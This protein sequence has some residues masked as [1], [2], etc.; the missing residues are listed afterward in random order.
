MVSSSRTEEQC[1]LKT[2]TT[3]AHK[4]LTL[5]HT[6]PPLDLPEF[7]VLSCRSMEKPDRV[8]VQ[9]GTLVSSHVSVNART[10]QLL[11]SSWCLIH[12]CSLSS[13]TKGRQG[14]YLHLPV[15][16]TSQ[17]LHSFFSHHRTCLCF[18]SPSCGLGGRAGFPLTRRSAVQSKSS[19]FRM[20]KCHWARY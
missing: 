8:T 3:M 5:K 6:P 7:F 9:P 19:P 13:L 4:D 16:S 14:L 20:L 15:L 18:S 1:F 11:I 10:Q 17:R 12:V 2:L